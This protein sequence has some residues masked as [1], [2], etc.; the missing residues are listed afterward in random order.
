[1]YH[2]KL[3]NKISKTGLAR[4]DTGHYAVGE[5]VAAPDAI[6]VRSADCQNLAFNPELLSIARAGAGVNNIPIDRCSEAGIVVFNTPGANAN[7]VKELV[8]CA[9]LLSSRDV[10]GGLKWAETLAAEG[11]AV[12]KLIEKGKGA[13]VGPELL[14]KRLGVIGLGAIGLLVANAAEKLGMEVFGFDPYLS[15]EHAWEMSNAVHYARDL[16]T[17]YESCDYITLHLPLTDGT[18]GML[19]AEAFGQMK[20]GMR[21]INLARGGLV[22]EPDLLKAIA[23]GIVACYAT[24]FPSAAMIGKKGVLA[25]PHLGAS[26]PESEENCA[27]M[28]A[29]QT[30][31]YL[32]N[33]NI[34]NSVNFPELKSPKTPGIS[35][36]CVLHKNIPNMIAGVASVLA[37]AGL[38]IESM[39][40]RSKSDYAYSG[41]DIVGDI[42]GECAAAVAAISGILRVR[43]IPRENGG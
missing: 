20:P 32:E 40:N 30:A 8:L 7:A 36:L 28:A 37:S 2:I 17:I 13:F 23:E 33:G 11:E 34:T 19:G 12:P 14:G 1:M 15:L 42:P 4:F 41:L 22:S 6:V 26:T 3:L 9:M 38:N 10:Y 16:K 27:L 35:R 5:D 31:D 39:H 21:L 18:K 25:I 24:D 29:A 43:V